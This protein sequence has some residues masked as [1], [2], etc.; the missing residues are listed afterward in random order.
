MIIGNDPTSGTVSTKSK[1]TNDGNGNT[2][3][4]NSKK[5]TS[6][7]NQTVGNNAAKGSTAVSSPSTSVTSPNSAVINPDT[8]ISAPGGWVPAGK[9]FTT[10]VI[11]GPKHLCR[12]S[13]PSFMEFSDMRDEVCYVLLIIE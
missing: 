7:T 9:K 10:P 6:T 3:N 5:S 12:P 11:E 8:L 2:N 4:N 13:W 1:S